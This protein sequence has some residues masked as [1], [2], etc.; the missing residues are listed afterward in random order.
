MRRDEDDE[1]QVL[2]TSESK[3]K[4]V[5]WITAFLVL[6]FIGLLAYFSIP[7]D[8]ADEG[9]RVEIFPVIKADSIEINMRPSVKL[10]TDS[11]NDVILNIYAL[12]NLSAELSLQMPSLT[13]TM[14]YFVLQAA[15][16]RKDNKE[17]VGDFVL[18]GKQLAKG[19][20]DIA[21]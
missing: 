9:D 2:G 3:P 11:I 17:I 21:L 13:D 12:R 18:K 7:D 16:I 14:I 4:Y 8:K 19:K 10:Q 20:Q 15:D 6:L 5:R 1:I